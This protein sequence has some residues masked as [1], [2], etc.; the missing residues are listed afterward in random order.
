MLC[1]GPGEEATGPIPNPLSETGQEPVIRELLS[2]MAS[3]RA[4]RSLKGARPMYPSGFEG[5]RGWVQC[6]GRLVWGG[7]GVLC[8]MYDGV[9]VQF[10]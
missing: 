5:A 4:C 6:V 8:Y 7:D 2:M 9:W 10:G 1:L 3:P